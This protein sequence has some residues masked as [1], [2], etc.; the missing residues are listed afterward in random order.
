[1]AKKEKKKSNITFAQV[2]Q[3][4]I[5]PRKYLLLFGLF[6]IIIRSASTLVIPRALKF[7]IDDVIINQDITLLNNI[8]I[9]SVGAIIIQASTSFTL[10]RLLSVQA[11]KLI[12]DLRVQVQKKMLS[13]PINFFDNNKSGALVSRIMTDVEGVRNI[14]GTGLARSTG[15]RRSCCP[16]RGRR[17]RAPRDRPAFRV[18]SSG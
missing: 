7:L 4:I 16:S 11:Q 10:T 13:L 5:L 17:C 6:L 1:M 3:T 14:V 15:R 2:Y 12:A 8:V 18:R 9:V